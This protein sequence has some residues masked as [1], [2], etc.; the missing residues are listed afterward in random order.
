MRL[1]PRQMPDKSI[2]AMLVAIEVYNK[3]IFEYREEAYSIL[4]VNV[5]GLLCLP[6]G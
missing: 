1:R 2:T 5:S 3:P 6:K 4:A